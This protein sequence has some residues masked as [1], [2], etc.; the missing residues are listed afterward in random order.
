LKEACRLRISNG[1]LRKIF[2]PERDELTGKSRRLH[3]EELHDLYSS[4]NFIGVVKSRRM[5]WLGHV[6][7]R[8]RREVHTGF[9]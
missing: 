8:G 7:R 2:G 4:P 9:W 3:V 6:A 5:I 1:E